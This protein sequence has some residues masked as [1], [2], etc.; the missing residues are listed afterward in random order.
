LWS[1]PAGVGPSRL[2]QTDDYKVDVTTFYWFPLQ[3]LVQAASLG[4][5][6]KKKQQKI[7]FSFGWNAYFFYHAQSPDSL[8]LLVGSEKRT[9]LLSGWAV[10]P[11]QQQVQPEKVHIFNPR[12]VQAEPT[13]KQRYHNWTNWSGQCHSWVHSSKNTC[14]HNKCLLNTYLQ[15]FW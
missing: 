12:A 14:K 15:L 6:Y 3:S 7:W 13:K 10:V 8:L 1:G 5:R 2:P 11:P 4:R 9:W